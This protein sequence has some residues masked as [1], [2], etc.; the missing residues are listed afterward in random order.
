MDVSGF[1]EY[2]EFFP[3]S[4]F[5]S[6]TTSD[7]R[8]DLFPERGRNEPNHG[9]RGQIYSSAKPALELNLLVYFNVVLDSSACQRGNIPFPISFRQNQSLPTVSV[10]CAIISTHTHIYIYLKGEEPVSRLGGNIEEG[11]RIVLIRL[12]DRLRMCPVARNRRR[13]V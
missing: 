8:E 7:P 9:E 1:G 2:R 12:A 11:I 5:V 6:L 4:S 3:S 10:P 13:P